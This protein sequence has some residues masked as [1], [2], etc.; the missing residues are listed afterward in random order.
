MAV[1]KSY[2]R[3]GLFLVVTLLVILA[4][5]LFF[6]QRIRTRQVIT[7]VTYTNEDVSG[8]DVSRPVRYRGVPIGHVSAVNVDP[9]IINIEIVF[10]VFKDRLQTFGVNVKS[11]EAVASAGVVERLRTEVVSNPVTGEAYLLIDRPLNPPPPMQ[12]GFTPKLPYIPSMPTKVSTLQERLP[13]LT[14]HAEATLQIL[15]QIV[16]KI[17]DT[18]ER[19][20][21]FYANV[22][23]ILQESEIP[24]LSGDS[25]K[26]LTT[27]SAQLAQIERLI[28]EMNKLNSGDTLAKLIQDTHASIEN[29]RAAIE[30]TRVAMEDTRAAIREANLPATA[31]SAREAAD[32]TGMAADDL[33]RSLPAIQ[34]S[35]APVRDLA[36]QFEEQPE[37]MVFGRRPK[38]VKRK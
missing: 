11:V 35:L 24:A 22:E 1:E 2:A 3:L 14:D 5:A 17:P 8:L 33:R 26:F 37:S 31:Q 29:T 30:N 18:L 34:E 32:R 19:S 9:R 12:L 36:R 6:I 27:Q 20:N 15:R 23:R 21:R 10:E 4:T 16:N 28:S 25:R 13:E 7:F 38:N